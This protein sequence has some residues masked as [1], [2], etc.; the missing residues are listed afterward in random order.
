MDELNLAMLLPGE[1]SADGSY[2]FSET[3]LRLPFQS[4]FTVE[5]SSRQ[6]SMRGRAR[7]HA[8]RQ[9][10]SFTLTLARDK[11]SQSQAEVTIALDALVTVT[12]RV[13]LLGPTVE[14]LAYDLESNSVLSARVVPLDRPRIYEVSGFL[15]L[16]GLK[17]FPF[18]FRVVPAEPHQ[19]LENVVGI[20]SRRRK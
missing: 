10:Y 2:G 17:W 3:G 4:S 9:T 20:E 13:A 19:A 7:Q 14:L 5:L 12:G 1:Y 15:S 6:L 11:E 16:H 8:G 18:W